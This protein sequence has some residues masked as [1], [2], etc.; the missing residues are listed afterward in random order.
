MTTS[1]DLNESCDELTKCFLCLHDVDNPKVLPCF[2]AF[3]LLCIGD[4]Y[5]DASPGD[6]CYCPIC[7]NAFTLPEKGVEQLPI[8]FF[9]KGLADVKRIKPGDKVPCE[10][11][12]RASDEDTPTV[13][14]VTTYCTTCGQ[15]LCDSCSKAHVKFLG[16]THKIVTLGSEGR[17]DL[18]RSQGSFCSHHPG[19][20]LEIYCMQCKV[21]V[22]CRC[23]AIK[24]K[25]HECYEISDL[26]EKFRQTILQKTEEV[27]AQINSSK[28]SREHQ[29]EV[30]ELLAKV[31][32]V[33][34]VIKRD[35]DAI[36]KYVDDAVT[37]IVR[38]LSSIKAKYAFKEVDNTKDRLDPDSA[39]KQ[40]FVRFARELVK[41]G[42]PYDVTD[43]YKD[44]ITRADEL[45]K[46]YAPTG[47]T[48][49]PDIA[50]TSTV[51]FDKTYEYIMENSAG[52][53]N[54]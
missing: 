16:A 7:R 9:L 40:I 24:H 47:D 5:R 1:T 12:L 22:C 44:L 34:T 30:K 17:E 3:C 38:Q 15:K 14:S 21:N 10:I 51:V 49:L 8:S 27:S 50:I 26:F 54:S 33:Q 6:Q 53:L 25:G 28:Q 43:A 45:I 19:N 29:T 2:H 52:E 46:R 48:R 42:K 37:Q 4:H 41:R 18:L 20:S 39:A 13:S 35:A 23:L 36:K 32:N 11:C 31:Q